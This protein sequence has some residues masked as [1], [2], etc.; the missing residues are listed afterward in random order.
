MN[1]ARDFVFT[2]LGALLASGWWATVRWDGVPQGP[3]NV[4]LVGL[5]TLLVSAGVAVWLIY[6]LLYAAFKGPGK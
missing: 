4:P 3:N 5:L 1:T 6:E 2:L